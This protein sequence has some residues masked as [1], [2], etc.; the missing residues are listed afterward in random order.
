MTGPRM[1]VSI[2]LRPDPAPI[3]MVRG[4]PKAWVANDP[5][6][7]DIGRPRPGST[8]SRREVIHNAPKRALKSRGQSSVHGLS[9]T[10][11]FRRQHWPRARHA[12][13]FTRPSAIDTDRNDGLPKSYAY[14][15]ARAPR[16]PGPE[17][18][19]PNRE[20]SIT[21]RTAHR[22][23]QTVNSGSRNG[24]ANREAANRKPCTVN[25]VP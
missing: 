14:S 2:G 17:P 7:P 12:K 11:V 1:T 23:P 10:P 22:T 15:P 16:N 20:P 5:D 18:H 3:F 6:L 8:T 19:R 25:R 21:D 9:L 13:T 4:G 24:S